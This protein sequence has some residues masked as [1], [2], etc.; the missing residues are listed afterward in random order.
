M[1]RIK[2]QGLDQ[3]PPSVSENFRQNL[4]NFILEKVETL[5]REIATEDGYFDITDADNPA[6]LSIT[7]KGFS[8]ELTKKILRQFAG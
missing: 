7:P 2:W 1:I 8:P 4:T 3:P 6:Q 5:G